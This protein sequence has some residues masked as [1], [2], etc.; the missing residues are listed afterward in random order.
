MPGMSH[1]LYHG[2]NTHFFRLC[3]KIPSIPP[4]NFMARSQMNSLMDGDY[5]HMIPSVTCEI[6]TDP[7]NIPF[8][9]ETNLPAP[10]C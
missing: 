7:E 6:N 4:L 5:I 3:M 1:S 9:V 8:L 10:I 2:N